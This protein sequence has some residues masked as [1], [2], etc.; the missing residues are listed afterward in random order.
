MLHIIPRIIDSKK[1]TESG[2]I[3]SSEKPRT[4]RVLR[5]IFRLPVLSVF[6]LVGLWNLSVSSNVLTRNLEGEG[7]V[8]ETLREMREVN[9]HLQ[10]HVYQVL[11]SWKPIRLQP[12]EVTIIYIDDDTFLG[13]LKGT[14]PTNRAYL[15]S[16][17]RALVTP[18]AHAG[19]IALD[20]DLIAPRGY[21][22]GTDDSSRA[23]DNTDLLNAIQYANQQRIPVVLGSAYIQDGATKR[24]LPGLFTEEE[25]RASGVTRCPRCSQFGYIN[26]PA[27][28]RLIPLPQEV[29]SVRGGKVWMKP[30]AVAVEEAY[31]EAE[32]S[33]GGDSNTDDD[34]NT[35]EKTKHE[36][37]SRDEEPIF[38][39]FLPETKYRTMTAL[40]FT[41]DAAARQQCDNRMILIG[42]HWNDMQ[43][44]GSVVDTHLSP[45]GMMSGIGLHANYAES[46]YRQQYAHELPLWADVV[47]DVLLGLLIYTCFELA[48]GWRVALVLGAALVVPVLCAYAAL[49]TANMYLDF[50]L[51]VEL[52]FLHIAY[53]LVEDY[54]HAKQHAPHPAE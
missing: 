7:G 8:R 14:Q 33:G 21:G 4:H 54:W 23:K 50:L 19:V 52:Y 49:V 36:T 32:G 3:L 31:L 18:P 48:K 12:N 37:V 13:D 53:E 26:A 38:G 41:N 15:A 6:L 47:L 25:L 40:Q 16:L 1:I 11:N 2:D 17:V 30:F 9:L 45:A 10:L 29:N 51:P 43:G 44:Y 39:T 24:Q 34:G 42:A 35:M 28:K 46:L 20:F 27:D 5:T 22:E